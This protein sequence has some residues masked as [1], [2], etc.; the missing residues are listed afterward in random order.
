MKT[1]IEKIRP[2]FAIQ[3]VSNRLSDKEIDELANQFIKGEFEGLDGE[4]WAGEI[5]STRK[6]FISGANAALNKPQGVALPIKREQ[7]VKYRLKGYQPIG[8]D[9][10]IPRELY[11]E[12]KDGEWYPIGCGKRLVNMV[13]EEIHVC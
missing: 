2:V 1:M 7:C 13:I 11:A 12:L 4:V 10:T 9:Y 5:E 6:T 8:I 3:N